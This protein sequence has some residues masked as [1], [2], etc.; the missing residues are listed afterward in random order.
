M[1]KK[2]SILALTFAVLSFPQPAYAQQ[3]EGEIPRIIERLPD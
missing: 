2:I 1:G 3:S